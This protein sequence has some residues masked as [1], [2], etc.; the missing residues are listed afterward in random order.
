MG[1]FGGPAAARP[2][3]REVFGGVPPSIRA[4]FRKLA[5]HVSN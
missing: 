4:Y 2:R 1:I 3:F 5:Q